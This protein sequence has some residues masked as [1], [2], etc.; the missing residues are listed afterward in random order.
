MHKNKQ[1]NKMRYCGLGTTDARLVSS[2]SSF[3]L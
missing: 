2:A 3:V 1:M